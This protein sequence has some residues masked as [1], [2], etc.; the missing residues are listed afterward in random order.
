MYSEF[1]DSYVR[2]I[3]RGRKY[4]IVYGNIRQPWTTLSTTI[5]LNITVYNGKLYGNAR[6]TEKI[7]K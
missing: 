2:Q 7:N 4:N 6:K 5:V 1:R 3:S